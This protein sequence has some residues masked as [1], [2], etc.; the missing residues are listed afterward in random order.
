MQNAGP[1]TSGP[2]KPGTVSSGALRAG[3]EN[4]GGPATGIPIVFD[5]ASQ[6]FMMSRQVV[7]GSSIRTVSEPVG[8]Y[9]ARSGVAFGGPQGFQNDAGGNRTGGGFNGANPGA[10]GSHTGGYSA[11]RGSGNSGGGY[12]GG[13]STS[14]ASGGG[15][16]SSAGGSSA[17]AS[18]GSGASAGG[19]GAPASGHR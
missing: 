9:L 12:Q 8:S 16:F 7:Q 18:V 10:T 11:S 5:H 19:A 1:A 14:H 3:I 2:N 17:G 15:S 6:S 4:K 13:S